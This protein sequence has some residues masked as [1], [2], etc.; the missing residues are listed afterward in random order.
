MADRSAWKQ[1]P[2]L[3]V[4]SRIRL[5]IFTSLIC[6]S[7]AFWRGLREGEWQH[8]LPTVIS[9]FR[10][11]KNHLNSRSCKKDGKIR[12]ASRLLC[13]LYCLSGG[14]LASTG[15]R[16]NRSL[17]QPEHS[18]FYRT[19]EPVRS[20]KKIICGNEFPVNRH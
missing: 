14:I 4:K 5:W 15:I 12:F 3:S 10:I 9:A 13:P 11:I 17:V 7:S 8:N 18:S 2:L 16:R 1:L 19:P 6:F 20:R